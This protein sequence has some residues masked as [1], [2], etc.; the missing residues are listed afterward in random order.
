MAS[1]MR[2]MFGE[3]V[4]NYPMLKSTAISGAGI[5]KQAL[6]EISRAIV[7]LLRSAGKFNTAE[8]IL[9]RTAHLRRGARGGL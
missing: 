2:S 8:K 9:E 4:L 5:T 1:F 3:H 7:F 6:Y